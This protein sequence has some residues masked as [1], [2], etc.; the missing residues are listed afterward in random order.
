[1][2][3]NIGFKSSGITP[4]KMRKCFNFNMDLS[5][6]DLKAATRRVWVTAF[7]D[8]LGPQQYAGEIS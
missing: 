8:S 1:M 6:R 2:R 7:E 5:T 3:S 4:D